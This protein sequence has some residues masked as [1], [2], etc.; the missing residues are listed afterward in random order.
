M[1]SDDW[2]EGTA[3]ARTPSCHRVPVPLSAP[4]SNLSTSATSVCSPSVK[5]LDIAFWTPLA[6][7]INM[8]DYL[9][10]PMEE[11]VFPCKGCGEVRIL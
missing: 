8:D 2:C 5:A 1:E 3:G 10:S 4:F 6:P 7:S 11:D 9:D